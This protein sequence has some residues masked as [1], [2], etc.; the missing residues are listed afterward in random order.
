MQCIWTNSILKR[1]HRP[2]E[3]NL[4]TQCHTIIDTPKTRPQVSWEQV[5]FHC[6]DHHSSFQHEGSILVGDF[7]YFPKE[8]AANFTEFCVLEDWICKPAEFISPGEIALWYE[9]SIIISRHQKQTLRTLFWVAFNLVAQ[10]TATIPVFS[11][12]I[13]A[14]MMVVFM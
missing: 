5:Y 9:F 10:Q 12:F 13:I 8:N 14:H 4:L 2:R 11:D 3:E 6:S 1:K 7:L